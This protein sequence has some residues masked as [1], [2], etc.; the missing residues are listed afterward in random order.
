[1]H[2]GDGAVEDGVDGRVVAALEEVFGAV[3][4]L[5]L[6]PATAGDECVAQSNAL[7]VRR[8]RVRSAVLEEERRRVRSDLRRRA[9][10]TG[11]IEPF[12]DRTA[13]E[14][15][16]ERRRIIGIERRQIGQ[17]VPAHDPADCARL[18]VEAD[19]RGEEAAT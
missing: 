19:G 13:E 15:G 2:E 6:D 8:H 18:R 17:R 1:M 16:G 5:E 12:A 3:D 11:L 7:V 9:R 10:G 14:V 4:R